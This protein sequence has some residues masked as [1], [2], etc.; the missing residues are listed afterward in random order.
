LLA[1]IGA[2]TL[3]R[4]AGPAYAYVSDE[5]AGIDV[6]DLDALAV[7]HT[8][9]TGGTGPRGIAVTGDGRYLLAANKITGDMSVLDRSTGAVKHKIKIGLNP[10]FIR[11]NG[12]FAFVT[13]EPAAGKGDT[14]GKGDGKPA[15]DGGKPG[16]K[17]D[18]DDA[19]KAEIA[20]VDLDHWRVVRRIV[21]GHET[22]GVEFSKNGRDILVTNEGDDTVSV[23]DRTTGRTVQEVSTAS[24]GK[25]PRGIKALPDGSGYVV[26]LEYS[27]RFIVLDD[28]FKMIKEAA[29][30]SGPYGVA[31]TPDG[32]KLLV[33][34]AKAGEL[35]VFDAK[36]YEVVGEI[37][38]GKRCW[39]FTFTPDG[40]RI[41]AACGRSDA[42]Y[43]V[44]ASTYAT[45]KVIEGA[46]GPWGIVTWPKSNGTLDTPK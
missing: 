37:P 44:D 3:A 11:V 34:A 46:R 45:V 19:V 6:I 27:D 39:H 10:E 32:S 5:R 12:H 7:V 17:D 25:R 14:P 15:A 23:Y 28:R 16:G 21:S 31:F 4:A 8:F 43:V 22:E 18:D 36:T 26:T 20:I 13:Y 2:A 24:Y 35:Q 30:K 38:V 41:L 29:T 40:S 1:L 9:P 42:V 33:A